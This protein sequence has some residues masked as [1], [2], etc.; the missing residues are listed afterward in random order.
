MNTKNTTDVIYTNFVYFVGAQELLKIGYSDN[1]ERRLKELNS[2]PLKLTLDILISGN[3]NTEKDFHNQFRRFYHNHEWFT[4]RQAIVREI[5]TDFYN[6]EPNRLLYVSEEWNS[7]VNQLK[8]EFHPTDIKINILP[9]P[10]INNPDK[11]EDQSILIIKQIP[12][13]HIPSESDEVKLLRVS[14]VAA[15]LT[16]SKAQVYR[17]IKSGEL[18][19]KWFGKVARVKSDDLRKYINDH[20][21]PWKKS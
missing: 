15:I 1:I 17:L 10:S 12:P 14:Q 19:S 9:P 5:I 11:K 18:P 16:V 21:A 4:N 2:G 6:N 8:N 20:N 13:G 3:M 7:I